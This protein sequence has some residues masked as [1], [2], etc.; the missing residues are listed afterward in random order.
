MVD[1]VRDNID[2]GAGCHIKP[3]IAETL[4]I[5]KLLVATIHI[6]AAN[7]KNFFLHLHAL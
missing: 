7:I 2:I 1:M 3:C 5:K 6:V 4:F